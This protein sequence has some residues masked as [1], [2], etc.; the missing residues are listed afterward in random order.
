MR[1]DAANHSM[2]R[3]FLFVALVALAA[4][5]DRL[6]FSDRVRIVAPSHA[7]ATLSQYLE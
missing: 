7:D 6:T 4:R 1:D 5:A 2:K 3:L